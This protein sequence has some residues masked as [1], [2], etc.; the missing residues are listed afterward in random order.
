[1]K[2]LQRWDC[3]GYELFKD[4][5]GDWVKADE[6]EAALA[7]R[8]GT[9]EKLNAIICNPAG[10]PFCTYCKTR[11]K[12]K[13][14]E[15]LQAHIRECQDHPL[16]AALMEIANLKA[17]VE[18]LEDNN[19][20]LNAA[21]VEAK[22]FMVQQENELIQFAE[23][24]QGWVSVED[25]TPKHEEDVHAWGPGIDDPFHAYYDNELKKWFV[26]HNDLWVVVSHWRP[27]PAAPKEETK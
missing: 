16:C 1:M 23:L 3:D 13:S 10:G 4:N 22:R 18:E 27:L 20:L 25:A 11:F 12:D 21:M 24:E 17:R 2:K 5:N 15:F 8:D 6:A 19:G 26:T 7:E 14:W 9:I